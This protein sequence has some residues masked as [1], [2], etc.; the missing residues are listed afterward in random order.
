MPTRWLSA[1]LS[2][3]G[4]EEKS[5]L[6]IGSWGHGARLPCVSLAHRRIIHYGVKTRFL[7]I[8]PLSAYATEGEPLLSRE[9]YQAFIRSEKC[10]Q[11]AIL[12]KRKYVEYHPFTYLVS[13]SSELDQQK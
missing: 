10:H 12:A 1:W 9:D 13:M 5:V 7:A 6:Y 8:P 3:K 11:T 4:R 2:Q